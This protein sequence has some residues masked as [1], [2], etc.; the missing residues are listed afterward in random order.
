MQCDDFKWEGDLADDCKLKT[1]D[2]FGA[3]AEEMDDNEWY[4]SVWQDLGSK[5]I[6]IFH[7]TENDIMPLSGDAA[8]ALCQLVILGARKVHPEK[9]MFRGW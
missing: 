2:G 6:T 3:H 1:D 5:Q 4:C 9:L 8:R 7:S